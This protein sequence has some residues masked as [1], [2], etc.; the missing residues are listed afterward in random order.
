MDVNNGLHQDQMTGSVTALGDASRGG[1]GTSP[2]WGGGKAFPKEG[3]LMG[4]QGEQEPAAEDRR[5]E[6]PGLAGWEERREKCGRNV[7]AGA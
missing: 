3:C 2:V 1:E 4:L 7:M 5:K 6:T